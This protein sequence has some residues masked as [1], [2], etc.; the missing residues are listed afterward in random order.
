MRGGRKLE[1]NRFAKWS[2]KKYTE[3]QRLKAMIPLG[4]FFLVI[5]PALLVWTSNID[6]RLNIPRI[7]FA[8]FNLIIAVFLIGIGLTFGLWANLIEFIEGEGTPVP[9]MPTQKLIATG[10][11]RYCRNPMAFGAISIYLGV[12]ILIGSLS[13]FI[14]LALLT[15]AL[16]IYIKHIEEKELEMRFGQ[17]YLEYKKR[18]PFIIPRR[19]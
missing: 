10:P 17:D 5:M 2:K 7:T 1:R 6:N 18:V 9:M 4:V 11:F 19:K 14:L 12:V 16:F 8:P 13:S 15:S 3:N